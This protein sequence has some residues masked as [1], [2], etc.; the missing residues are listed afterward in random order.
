M[1]QGWTYRQLKDVTSKISD[2]SHNPPKGIAYSEY[3]ML[4]SKNILF[5]DFN[6]D[7]PR[8][9]SKED[10]DI[11]NKRTDISDGDVLL[12]IVGTVGRTCCVQSPFIPF[13]LQRSVA[14]LKPKK[15]ILISRFLMYALYSLSDLWENEAKGAAQK[16]VYLKQLAALSIPTPPLAEQERIVE[17]L[18][19]AFAQIDELK[20]N[21][22]RQLA[23]ARALFQSALTQA[24]QPKPGWQEK[25]IGDICEIVRGKRFVRADIVDDGV[26]CIHYGDI[27]TYYGL[28]ATKTR[29]Y[30]KPELAKKMRFA[31][32]NDVVVV[33]AGENNWDIGV[34]VA[35]FGEEPAAVHDACFIL[36]H[37]Q[38]PMFISYY[39]RSYNYHWYLLDYVHEGKICSFLKP[40]LEKAPIPLPPLSEQHSIVSTLDSL[41]SKVDR[42]QEIF[43]KVSQECDALKQAILRQIFE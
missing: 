37:K 1:K 36:R 4:S 9:L 20:S 8:Y 18:D 23:E 15:E 13:T 41:K 22:E 5:D 2:G 25:T 38:D 42:L 31:K 28:S 40:A 21:A 27:Y 10:F 19:A 33:Q 3:P 12:T 26:P 29:G 24:M 32:K 16:G 34:G 7:S 35:Y 14:V 17:R 30:L 39:L 43:N 11:E 6:Y